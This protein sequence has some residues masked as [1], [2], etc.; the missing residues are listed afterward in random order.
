MYY[1][2]EILLKI[3]SSD[4][5]LFAFVEN[6]HVFWELCWLELFDG[7]NDKNKKTE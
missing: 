3:D 2:N 4:K 1:R 5:V 6:P 7:H